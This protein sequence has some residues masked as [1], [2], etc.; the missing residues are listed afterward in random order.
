MPARPVTK[1]DILSCAPKQLL[2]ELRRSICGWD[3]AVNQD[4]EVAWRKWRNDIQIVES[5]FALEHQSLHVF[6]DVSEVGYGAVA[7]LRCESVEQVRCS[8]LMGKSRVAP[9]EPVTILRLELQVAVL[10]VRLMRHLVKQLEARFNK[11]YFWTDSVVVL[12]Y[13]FSTS[14]TFKTFVASRLFP[15]MEIPTLLNGDMFQPT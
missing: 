13:I 4:V 6:S 7:Y 14:S 11:V 3:K 10:A 8:F 9:L 2:Q 12:H 5:L 15:Y 1:R